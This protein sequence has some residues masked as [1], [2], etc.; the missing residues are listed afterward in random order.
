MGSTWKRS[1]REYIVTTL[2]SNIVNFLPERNK[3]ETLGSFRNKKYYPALQSIK[4]VPK[5][6]LVVDILKNVLLE[7]N[8]TVYPA[9]RLKRFYLA[10]LQPEKTRLQ[11]FLD[12]LRG[13]WLKKISDAVDAAA[14]KR[15]AKEQKLLEK[16][17]IVPIS[18]RNSL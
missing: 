9:E 13:Y 16:L 15:D 12:P 11:M 10:A 8:G 6:T 4:D 3:K 5:A 18:E 1:Q 2:R 14:V 17:G 7:T